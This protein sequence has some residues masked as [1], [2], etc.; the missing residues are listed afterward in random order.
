METHPTLRSCRTGRKTGVEFEIGVF[1]TD[2]KATEK[3]AI[4]ETS[5]KAASPW[6]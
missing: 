1:R 3:L 6:R 4:T 5:A 2:Q